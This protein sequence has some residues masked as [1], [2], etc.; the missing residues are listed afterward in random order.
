MKE[1]SNINNNSIMFDYNNFNTEKTNLKCYE[2]STL[3]LEAL[4]SK[5][6]IGIK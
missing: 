1:K 5:V 6:I 3:F 4:T 2:Y